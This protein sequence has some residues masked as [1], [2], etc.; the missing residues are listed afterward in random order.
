[1]KRSNT[2][3]ILA[4][5]SFPN[6]P[7]PQEIGLSVLAT[8]MKATTRSRGSAGPTSA[9]FRACMPRIRGTLALDVPCGLGRHTIQLDRLGWCAVAADINH[10]SLLDLRASALSSVVLV[11]VDATRPL[12]FR[13]GSFDLAV[14]IHAL[15][16]DVLL[17]V[18]PVVRQGGHIIFETFGAQGDNWRA[19][20]RPRQVI[21]AL[22]EDFEA[23]EYQEKSV[24]RSPSAVTVKA[25]FQRRAR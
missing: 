20:P 6:P 1:M 5:Q 16:L 12:P 14:V 4:S 23:L 19:L 13:P 18:Q 3:P 15:S 9:F 10:R 2:S 25:L 24:G 22:T 21:T 8:Y 11:R 7:Q 17:R